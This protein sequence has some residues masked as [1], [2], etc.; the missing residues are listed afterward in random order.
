MNCQNDCEAQGGFWKADG[1]Q[2]AHCLKGDRTAILPISCNPCLTWDCKDSN[3]GTGWVPELPPPQVSK[4]CDDLCENQGGIWADNQCTLSNGVKLN[5][6]GTELPSIPEV[7]KRLL[8]GRA[9]ATSE[10]KETHP[11][12]SERDEE[13]ADHA[14]E[15]QSGSPIC[16]EA[17][18]ASSA[19]TPWIWYGGAAVAAWFLLRTL[20]R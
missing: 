19:T 2:A 8:P 4:M 11:Q 20:R 10:A 13:M 3:G 15:S 18:R 6:C 7:V 14:R 9:R 5:V 12:I 16:D 17:R 1:P